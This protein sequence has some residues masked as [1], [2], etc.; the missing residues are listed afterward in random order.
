MCA[1]QTLLVIQTAGPGHDNAG[2]KGDDDILQSQPDLSAAA[3]HV[4]ESYP[5]TMECSVR[6]DNVVVDCH[7]DAASISQPMMETVIAHFRQALTL[8]I[9][10]GVENTKTIA[11]MDLCSAEDKEAIHSWNSTDPAPQ[12]VDECLHDMVRRHVVE[13]PEA[14]AICGW[15][16]SLT[17][18]QLGKAVRRLAI[19]LGND[20]GVQVGDLVPICMEKSTWALV[21][22]L[23]VMEA[24]AA[25][26]PLDPSHPIDRR[27][28]IID[29]ISA[30]VL[31]VDPITVDAFEARLA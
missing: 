6:G 1:F 22:M 31:M 5:I 2:D 4:F 15:D 8:L 11:S 13:R 23:A 18:A 20:A 19:H 17:Y 9:P 24:G 27:C 30:K 25:F 14:E 26:V 12:Q 7:F 21:A 16:H 28:Q 29:D 10:M 3:G